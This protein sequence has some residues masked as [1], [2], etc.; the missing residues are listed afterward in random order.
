MCLVAPLNSKPKS[1]L[2]LPWPCRTV[3]EAHRTP[4]IFGPDVNYMAY[5]R[6]ER[7][8]GH[9]ICTLAAAMRVGT[10]CIAMSGS[11]S[12]TATR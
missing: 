4:G 10:F 5:V 2:E 12:S 11:G 9:A 7:S 1:D 6:Q 8:M 3:L